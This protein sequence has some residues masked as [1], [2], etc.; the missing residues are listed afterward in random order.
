MTAPIPPDICLQPLNAGC[1]GGKAVG[2]VGRA[3]LGDFAD[4]ISDAVGSVLSTL[5]SFWTA[6]PT[7]AVS[8]A[9]GN[10]TDTV[11]FL[12]GSLREYTLGLAVLSV[13]IGGTKMAWEQRAEPG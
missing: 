1:T 13:I 9:A 7:P 2:A 11:G 6:T 10:A 3:V 4:A 5:G 12:Q 8:D